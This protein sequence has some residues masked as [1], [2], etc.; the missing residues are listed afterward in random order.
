MYRAKISKASK[1]SRVMGTYLEKTENLIH[2]CHLQ[3]MDE[4]KDNHTK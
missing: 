1:N 2:P 4:L 3:H